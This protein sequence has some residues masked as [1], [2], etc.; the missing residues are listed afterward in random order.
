VANLLV[1]V[2]VTLDDQ[3]VRGFPITRRVTLDEVQAAT[4]YEKATGGGF[5]DLPVIGE[6]TT[7]QFL[8][9][10][11]DKALSLR[12]GSGAAGD[13]A[14]AANALVLV[15]DANHTADIEVDNSS[16]STAKIKVIAGGT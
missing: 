11:G 12:F 15:V 14:L 4:P 10:Q 1:E 8:L 2:N 6:L 5:V 9:F 13:I 3:P 7:K 16:G